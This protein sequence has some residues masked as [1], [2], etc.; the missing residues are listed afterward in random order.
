MPAVSEKQR[1]AMYAAA[2]G[3][4]TLGIPSSVGREFVKKDSDEK[5]KSAGIVYRTPSGEILLIKRG[6]EQ[7]HPGEWAFPGGHLKDD[8]S[9]KDAAI[10]EFNEEVGGD[11]SDAVYVGKFG[12]FAAFVRDGAS[13]DVKLSDESQDYGYF[14]PHALPTPMHPRALE[15]LESEDLIRAGMHE[16][17]IARLMAAGV[18]SSP[19]Q[20][21]NSV[22]F[23]IRI[24]GTGL[25]YRSA[26]EEFTWRSPN[27]YL[28]GDFLDR[29]NGLMVIL[30]HP[31][32]GLLDGD[33]LR[34]RV[35]GAVIYP[36]IDGDDVMGI[37]RIIDLDA[38]ELMASEQLS[39]SPSVVTAR[40]A[41]LV[42][43]DG[44][45]CNI[46]GAPVVLDHVAICAVGVWDK[47]GE[48]AG[49]IFND[50]ED[51]IMTDEV[52]SDTAADPMKALADSVG[53]IMTRLD[54]FEKK[55][56]KMKKK[57]D[58]AKKDAGKHDG[59]PTE[60]LG[61]KKADAAALKK[62]DGQE[63][64][65]REKEVEAKAD[66]DLRA[67]IERMKAALPTALSDADLNDLSAAQSKA[68][69]V[70]TRFGDRA[71]RYMQGETPS[72]Y[73]RRIA[74]SLQKHSDKWRSID[75][76]G[77]DDSTF[78]I[79][80]GDIYADSAKA[81]AITDAVARDGELRQVTRRSASGH[82]ITEFYGDQHKASGGF[83]ARPQRAIFTQQGK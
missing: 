20:Y 21:A 74:G 73:R 45:Q 65:N 83:M 40:D 60:Q 31:K 11:V 70:F 10:R 30:D 55:L 17:D 13:F 54:S 23:K 44:S 37:A 75:I 1:R 43:S 64:E 56:D 67:E 5:V 9:P 47:G 41:T 33:E 63:E 80:E 24:T 42:L 51:C 18:L 3:R 79:A 52:K 25:A 7:D 15:I 22:L 2:E 16:L 35:I 32:K 14:A 58:K 49:V 28:T 69:S 57:A 4:S 59:E 50:S 12:K 82:T 68:D 71:P 48:P 38:A 81:S 27:D 62:V 36:F 53:Q 77:L 66:S 46:E 76:N 78:A 26:N 61:D 39:T 6:A 72:R 8:E 34:K 29:C 19:Q